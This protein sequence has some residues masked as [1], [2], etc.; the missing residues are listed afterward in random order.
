MILDT[1]GLSALADGDPQ[2]EPMLRKIHELAIP[3]IVLGE[4]QYGI[5]QSRHR[6][7][8]AE[9]LAEL[10]ANCRV[11]RID[12]ATASE[13]ATIRGE[14]KRA[15]QPIPA[16]DAWIAAL[17]RQHALPVISRDE[18]FDFVPNIERLGW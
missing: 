15:G 12:E 16:N 5:A 3:V 14:L 17:A 1:N 9:W 18:H 8:Y 13:Y 2:L 7:R 6:L 11:L 10:V 4:Y